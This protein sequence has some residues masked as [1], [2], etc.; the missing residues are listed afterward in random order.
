LCPLSAVATKGYK[1]G[2]G[3][4]F[5]QS[6]PLAWEATQQDLQK[7]NGERRGK[8]NEAEERKTE[9]SRAKIVRAV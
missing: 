8:E 2:F 9:R 4:G 1:T 6:C 3:A 7:K 5:G